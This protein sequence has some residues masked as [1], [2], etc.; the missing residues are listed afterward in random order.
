MLSFASTATHCGSNMLSL[1]FSCRSRNLYLCCA[2]SK[3]CTPCRPGSVRINGHAVRPH[4]LFV[5]GL[6]RNSVEQLAPDVLLSPRFAFGTEGALKAKLASALQEKIWRRRLRGNLAVLGGCPR[7]KNQHQDQ[8]AN[9]H[10]TMQHPNPGVTQNTS[11][12]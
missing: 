7:R 8:T 3:M 5:V 12:H 4:H 1:D 6:A 11:N 2:A 9:P 10:P